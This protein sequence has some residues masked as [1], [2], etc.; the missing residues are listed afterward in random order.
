MTGDFKPTARSRVKRRSNRAHY[1]RA[2]VY[3]VVDA[4]VLAHVGYVIDG[5]PYVTPTNCWREGDRLLWHGS[6]A[7]RMLKTVRDRVPVCVTITH[8][9]GLVMAR[10]AFHH[11]VNYRSVMLFGRA[12]MVTDKAEKERALRAFV[13]RVA[14]GR[15]PELRPITAQ[16]LKATMVVA[17]PIEEASAKIRTGPPVD[18]EADHALPVWAGVV[19]LKLTAGRPVADPRLVPGTPIPPSLADYDIEA[20]GGPRVPAVAA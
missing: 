5:Q 3:A 1:D 12:E 20:Y 11:S 2:T 4:A 15:W 7:S 13:E 10:S 8:L 9:D 16:E 6:M 17:M 18:D 19:P 14:P